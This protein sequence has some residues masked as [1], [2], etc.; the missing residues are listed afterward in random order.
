MHDAQEGKQESIA[1][2]VALGL[3]IAA[4]VIAVLVVLRPHLSA[5]VDLVTTAI[6]EPE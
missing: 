1:R 3:M 4:V 5:P 6:G 2:A